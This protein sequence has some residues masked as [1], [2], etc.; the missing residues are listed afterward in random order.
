MVD[1]VT[2]GI[3]SDSSFNYY[4]DASVSLGASLSTLVF[5]P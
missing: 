3:S 5:Y 2:A 1:L 4:A